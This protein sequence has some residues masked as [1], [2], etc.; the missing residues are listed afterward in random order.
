[1]RGTDFLLDGNA[2]EMGGRFFYITAART[3]GTRDK[4]RGENSIQQ[5]TGWFYL[6]ILPC[7]YIT[8]YSKNCICIYLAKTYADDLGMCLFFCI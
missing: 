4:E 6:R 8:A 7:F 2:E 5:S 3:A 1:M